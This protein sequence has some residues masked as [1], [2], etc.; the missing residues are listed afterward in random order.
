MTTILSFLPLLLAVIVIA[1]ILLLYVYIAEAI[2]N[3]SDGREL[4][5][6][7]AFWIA[8]LLGPIIGLIVVFASRKVSINA[9]ESKV[10]SQADELLKLSNLLDKGLISREE[11]DAQKS[12]LLK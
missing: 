11:F 8:F 5:H 6:K 9:S 3:L 12:K 2:A 10:Y 4:N 7:T 1:I